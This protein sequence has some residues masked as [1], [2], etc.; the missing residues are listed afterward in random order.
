MSAESILARIAPPS[1][2]LAGDPLG[3]PFPSLGDAQHSVQQGVD[4]ATSSGYPHLNSKLKGPKRQA[5]RPHR[6]R[7]R[8][9]RRSVSKRLAQPPTGHHN[10][11]VRSWANVAR[12]AVKGSDLSFVPPT[13][14]DG[15]A[16][17]NLPDEALNAMDPKWHDCLVGYL[18]GRRRLPFG[19]L[20]QALRKTWGSKIGEIFADDRGFLFLQIPDPEFRR[21]I[22][23]EGPVTIARVPLILRQLKLLMDLKREDRHSHLDSPAQLAA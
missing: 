2:P 3:H 12:L 15:E 21:K 16:I 1:Q 13:F 17:V 9:R 14:V 23:E 18:V 10:A 20:E 6:S 22:L 7:G 19:L 11:Q 8:S 4:M 5:S